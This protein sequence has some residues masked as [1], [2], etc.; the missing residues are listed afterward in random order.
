MS[1]RYERQRDLVPPN[2]LVGLTATIIGI[3]AIGRQIAL[4]LAAIGVPRLQLI[5]FDRVEATNLASQGYFQ[6]D[7]GQLKVAATRRAVEAIDP[8]IVVEACADRFR[9]KQSVGDVIFCAVDSISARASIWRAVE[10]R[11]RCWTDGR[12]LGETIRVLCVA[13]GVGREHYSSTLFRPSEAQAGRCTSRSTIYA[14][15]IAAGLLVH[16]STRWLRGLPRHDHGPFGQRMDGNVDRPTRHLTRRGVGQC[17]FTQ[18]SRTRKCMGAR[19]K[20][21]EIHAIIA[22]VAASVLGLVTSSWIVFGISLAVLL[23]AKLHSGAI[24][25]R[26]RRP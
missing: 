14:S 21:N 7:E 5:D 25:T 4:Q 6:A 19:Q 13:D 26:N 15:A 2:R 12:M 22:V 17:F 11:C 3:G 16:Q 1:D 24:R 23:G 9:P 20:L 8:T 18:S 10:H